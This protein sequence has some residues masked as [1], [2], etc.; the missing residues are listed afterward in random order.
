MLFTLFVLAKGIF[1]IFLLNRPKFPN[2]KVYL[3]PIFICSAGV[4]AEL[5]L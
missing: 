5:I 2:P 4:V 1:P 3:P